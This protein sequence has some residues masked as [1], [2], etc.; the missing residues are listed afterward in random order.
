L[1]TPVRFGEHVVLRLSGAGIAPK[2]R[3]SIGHHDVELP[4]LG[5][6]CSTALHGGSARV[7][8]D[9]HRSAAQLLDSCTV[10]GESSSSDRSYGTD[11]MPAGRSPLHR[12]GGGGVKRV[13]VLGATAP[14]M[15]DPSVELVH[16]RLLVRACSA[17]APCS[18]ATIR[19]PGVAA[20]S[21]PGSAGRAS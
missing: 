2:P 1:N 20:R 6:P 10:S 7:G 3:C 11:L 16:H 12:A 17:G 18:A 14:V 13:N 8:L 9:G 21:S 5:E 4:E 19:T 15:G